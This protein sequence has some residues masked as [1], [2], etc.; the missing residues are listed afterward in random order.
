MSFKIYKGDTVVDEGESPLAITGL[1]ANIDVAAG[2]Y[3]AVRVEG[4]NES[5]R[6]DIPAFKTLPIKVTGVTAAPKTTAADSGKADGANVTVTVAPANATNKTVTYSIAP[7]V[8]GLSVSNDGRITW[9]DAVPPGTYT[10]TV[11]TTDGNKTD[12]H[13]LTLKAPVIVVDGVTISPKTSA[14]EIG[15]SG[16]RQLSAIVSPANADDKGVTFS[17]DTVEGLSVSD[18][19]KIE[20]TESTPAGSYTTTVKT[21]DG[22]FTDTHVLTLEDP[23]EIEEGE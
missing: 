9:I 16:N 5:E 3:Q 12:T 14:A 19:G 6:V 18:S 8:D 17:I 2:D 15:A 1:S 7:E 21:N 20:W 11:K 13:V 10:T 22:G 4:D 23:P